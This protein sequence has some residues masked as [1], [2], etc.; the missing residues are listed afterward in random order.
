MS[1]PD[2]E[3]PL[4]SDTPSLDDSVISDVFLLEIDLEQ[5]AES[6]VERDYR[7]SLIIKG[8][9]TCAELL[10]NIDKNCPRTGAKFGKTLVMNRCVK[11]LISS[12]NQF[13]AEIHQK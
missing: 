8:C 12:N 10:N 9:L 3:F 13:P 7:V 2:V 4:G 5:K 11:Y 6:D 1:Q